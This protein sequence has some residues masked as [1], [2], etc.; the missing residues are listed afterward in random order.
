MLKEREMRLG[1]DERYLGTVE[2]HGSTWDLIEVEA[3]ERP[4][5]SDRFRALGGLRTYRD[6]EQA[7]EGVTYHEGEP[8]TPEQGAVDMEAYPMEWDMTTLH[9][10]NQTRLDWN[11]RRGSGGNFADRVDTDERL[12]EL[13][14]G[15]HTLEAYSDSVYC[16]DC[17]GD[18]LESYDY[19]VCDT[20]EY[21]TRDEY[22]G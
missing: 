9:F 7:A 13:I 18:L 8:V 1:A 14:T 19:V 17:G 21:N 2:Y 20:C 5:G 12:A 15:Y 3:Q 10:A 22:H 4:D 16:P 11:T 6:H